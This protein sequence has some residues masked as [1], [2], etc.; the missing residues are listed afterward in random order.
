M[1]GLSAIIDLSGRPVDPGDIAPI[2][3]AAVGLGSRGPVT[4]ARGP[5]AMA[6]L[7][8]HDDLVEPGDDQPVYSAELDIHLVADARLDER[9]RL[10]REVAPSG[11]GDGPP[12]PDS[13]LILAAFRRWGTACVPHLLGDFA[14]V[15]HDARLRRVFAARDHAGVR[16]LAFARVGERLVFG[17]DIGQVLACS[18]V[19]WRLDEFSMAR[20]LAGFGEDPARSFFEHVGR[21]PPGGFLLADRGRT[22]VERWWTP[23]SGPEIR[24]RHSDDYAG[25]CRAH[26][27]QAVGDRLRGAGPVVGV[28]VSGGLDSTSVAVLAADLAAHRG[29]PAVAAATMIFDR[30][31]ECDERLHSRL[32]TTAR[33]IPVHCVPAE[34]HALGDPE[35]GCRP[36][37]DS[38]LFSWQGAF[39]AMRRRLRASGVRVA[40]SGHEAPYGHL[41]HHRIGYLKSLLGGR[42]R[43]VADIRAHGR[44]LGLD[45]RHTI[46][47]LL[48]KPLLPRWIHDLLRRTR[49]HAPSHLLP[50]WLS[51]DFA[52]RSGLGRLAR[53]PGGLSLLFPGVSGGEREF[54]PRLGAVGSAIMR[55]DRE[56]ASDGME[57]RHP[58][59]DRRLMEYL[60]RLPPEQVLREGLTKSVLRRAMRGLLPEPIRLRADKT[61]FSAYLADSR[62]VLAERR[63]PA[64]FH[65]FELVRRGYVQED[66][67]RSAWSGFIE[68]GRWTEHLEFTLLAESWLSDY[69]DRIP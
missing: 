23:A 41:G 66:R 20:F 33:G 56:E 29:G 26:L 35:D 48:L 12:P 43:T 63:P 27:L 36:T 42:W 55:R 51:E 65:D 40:L 50:G 28:F 22:R 17:S 10:W 1:S 45:A 54:P 58:L 16:P 7:A 46:E 31:P 6:W 11:R 24:H 44:A 62:R 19:P 38:P 52:R 3:A 9:E 57:A 18:A 37:P 30:L 2:A 32:L 5:V 67:L 59:L 25:E 14:F 39:A 34:E 47:S 21:V 13:R 4:R 15:L 49:G 69:R 64:P 60:A 61:R 53:S 8:R 68:G